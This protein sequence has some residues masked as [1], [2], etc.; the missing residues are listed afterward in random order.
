MPRMTWSEKILRF[1]VIGGVFLLPFIPLVV[2]SSLFFPFITGKNFLFRIIVEI[3]TFCYLALVLIDPKYRPRRNW[4]FGAFLVFIIVIAIADAQ[5]VNPFKS[6][7]SNFERMDGWITIAHLFCYLVVAA[8]V[9][10][11]EKWWQRLFEISLGVSVFIDLWGFSQILGVAASDQGSTAGLTARID[12]TFGNPIYL[13]VYMLFHAFLA[14]LLIYQIG[15]ERWS[16]QDRIV[17]PAALIVG[18]LY[19]AAQSVQSGGGL[20]WLAILLY[21]VILG[22]IVGFMFME[23]RYLYAFV[24]ALDTIALFFTGTRGTILGLIGGAVLA[25]V[26]YAFLSPNGKRMRTYVIT[27]IVALVVVSGGLWLARDTG[28]VRAV[29]FLQRLSSISTGDT[30]I[31]SR[32]INIETAWKGIEERPILGWGQEEYAIVF[33]KFYD[34]RMYTDEP[35]F[36]RVHDIVFDWWV[37]G[38][39]LGL[40]AYLSVLFAYLWVLWRS[41]AFTLAERSILTGLL[42]G[43][44]V[45]NLTVFDNITSYILFGT[46][47]AYLVYRAGEADDLP[48]LPAWLIP[49]SAAPAAALAAGV[50]SL[51]TVWAVNGKAFEQNR[52]ILSGLAQQPGGL[53]Q[54]L[55]NFEQATSYGAYGEQEAREQLAQVTTELASAPPSQVGT[56]TELAFLN[57]SS[58][59]MLA[60]EQAAP[61]DARFPLFLGTMLDAYG[62]Y[63]DAA[64]QLQL[65][66]Q[67]SPDKQAILYE[68]GANAEG[69]GDTAGALADF[70]TAYNLDTNDLDARLYYAAAAIEAGNDALGSQLLA[71]V[72]AS[73]QAADPR[74]AQAYASRGEYGK[75]VSIWQAAVQADPSNTQNYFTLAAAYYAGGDSK[76]AIAELK[77][78]ETEDP[79]SAQQANQLIQE[80]QNGTIKVTK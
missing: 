23:R 32:I 68:L 1:I 60:Q 72:T 27:A 30:T 49:R 9:I 4:I 3:I 16:M 14:T 44:F 22:G 78:A 62:Q 33:D 5:G 47:L 34:P 12:A 61:L 71:P 25:W 73:G 48:R 29:G 10:T 46:V 57:F 6:F 74:I 13:A 54:N 45:H 19:I 35:W 26:I 75:I 63:A 40:L 50:L 20:S 2:T 67:L 15:K 24:I 7:W 43:Y 77:A 59:Q 64:S 17:F 11:V 41:S 36:D 52:A 70:A 66:H 39:T 55:S 76:D 53:M 21:F 51:A 28:P 8:S 38:G 58:Q 65:A 37:A 79:S 18:L 80:I 69:R 31:Q 42:A 56:S